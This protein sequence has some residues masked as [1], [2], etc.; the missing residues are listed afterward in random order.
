MISIVK[1]PQYELDLGEI[2]N[3]IAQHNSHAADGAVT[4]IEQTIELLGEFPRI[5]TLCPHLAPRAAPYRLAGVPDILPR[6]R[7]YG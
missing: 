1:S 6:G 7:G 3:Y 5:G 4:A 2:W